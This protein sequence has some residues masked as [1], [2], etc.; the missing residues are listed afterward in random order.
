VEASERDERG[1][2]VMVMVCSK[3]AYCRVNF[4]SFFSIRRWPSNKNR[5]GESELKD[6]LEIVCV[7]LRGIL[8]RFKRHL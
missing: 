4:W 1:E 6:L 5:N 2:E 7:G 3:E 8:N